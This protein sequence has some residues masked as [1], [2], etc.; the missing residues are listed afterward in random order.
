MQWFSSARE[1]SKAQLHTEQMCAA[2]S[3]SGWFFMW[4]ESA[5]L[6]LKDCAQRPQWW[7]AAEAAGFFAMAAGAVGLTKE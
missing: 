2:G 3:L 6:L 1:S 7:V 5:F 4:L